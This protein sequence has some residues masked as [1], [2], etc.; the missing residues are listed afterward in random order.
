[1]DITGIIEDKDRGQVTLKVHD[2]ISG[3]EWGV[4][5]TPEEQGP[6]RKGESDADY[7][8]RLRALA[9]EL[10]KR[11]IAEPHPLAGKPPVAPRGPVNLV[12]VPVPLTDAAA[13][14]RLTGF[15]AADTAKLDA[16]RAEKVAA[17]EAA[18]AAEEKV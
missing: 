1:M 4:F 5:P 17:I 9:E 12:E 10:R 7:D 6:Q 8:A 13:V 2:P 16:Y 18:A 15:K 11:A 3:L 14:S